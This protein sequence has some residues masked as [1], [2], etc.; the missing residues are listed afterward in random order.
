MADTGFQTQLGIKTYRDLIEA[1]VELDGI[2]QNIGTDDLRVLYTDTVCF[3]N[4]FLTEI[5]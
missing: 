2:Y 4:H 1:A 3:F 5:G